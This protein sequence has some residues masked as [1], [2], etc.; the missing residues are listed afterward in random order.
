MEPRGL[1]AEYTWNPGPE[2]MWPSPW[3]SYT[4]K[5]ATAASSSHGNFSKA[6]PLLPRPSQEQN[7]H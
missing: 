1:Q 5:G 4:R 3:I 7:C 6:I 2:A